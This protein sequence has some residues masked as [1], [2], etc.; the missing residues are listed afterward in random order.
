[1]KPNS[2]TNGQKKRSKFTKLY[3]T[4]ILY[5]VLPFL[6]L[7]VNTLHIKLTLWCQCPERSF[8]AFD[9]G[10]TFDNGKCC[11]RKLT[12]APNPLTHPLEKF[13]LWSWPF[14]CQGCCWKAKQNQTWENPPRG[15]CH[16]SSQVHE[17]AASCRNHGILPASKSILQIIRSK[18]N[19]FQ[20]KLSNLMLNSLQLTT[21]L[22]KSS[23]ISRAC[24]RRASII[25]AGNSASTRIWRGSFRC[26]YPGLPLIISSYKHDQN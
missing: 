5:Y 20:I 10:I 4:I 11:C 21:G 6:N 18:S 25:S 26:S 22:S 16:W 13:T 9:N 14:S 2:L 7:N 19:S 1:M 3:Q 12:Q 24:I 23:S 15:E 8:R 17:A